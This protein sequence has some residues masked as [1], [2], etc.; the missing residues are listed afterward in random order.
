ML[1]RSARH[2]FSLVA[3]AWDVAFLR[4][5]QQYI[6]Y[7]CLLLAE[8]ARL[9]RGEAPRPIPSL[10][11]PTPT[12]P[13]RS[14][15]H[16]AADPVAAT[17]AIAHAPVPAAAPPVPAPVPMVNPAPGAATPAPQAPGQVTPAQAKSFEQEASE[18]AN[19]VGSALKSGLSKL[20]GALDA[21][22]KSLNKPSVGMRVLVA[23][24]DGHKY[25]GVIAEIGQGQYFVTM[26]DGRQLWV[27]EAY[28]SSTG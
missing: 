11:E 22:G 14:N 8:M 28:V 6:T 15:A 24:S 3:F 18:A 1:F 21:F 13:E 16:Q 19:A 20:G 5:S 26:T 4:D 12:N 23:W 2:R 17:P 7:V 9:S 25:P 10:H 27:P